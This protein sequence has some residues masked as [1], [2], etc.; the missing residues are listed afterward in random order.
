MKYSTNVYRI[1]LIREK[2][3][4]YSSERL[5]DSQNAA[6]AA[7]KAI[8]KCGQI[9]REQMVI[10]LLSGNNE[11]IGI[12][13]AHTGTIS[14][15]QVHPREIFKPAIAGNTSNII[16]VH[17]HPSGDCTPSYDDIAITKRIEECGKLLGI[18]LLDH[19]I[20]NPENNDFYS[21]FTNRRSWE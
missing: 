19:I 9:D 13:I 20:V 2:Q 16:M 5:S 4:T 18:N 8:R 12:N 11:I 14:S 15:C 21:M 17:N 6:D 1:S 10:L 3:I 7:I